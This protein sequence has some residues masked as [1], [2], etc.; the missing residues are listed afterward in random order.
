MPS[1]V[2]DL[3][4]FGVPQGFVDESISNR[5]VWTVRRRVTT[6]GAGKDNQEIVDMATKRRVTTPGKTG[7]D[8]PVS[9]QTKRRLNT[10]GSQGADQSVLGLGASKRRIASPHYEVRDVRNLKSVKEYRAPDIPEAKRMVTEVSETQRL[11]NLAGTVSGE[12]MMSRRR[13]TMTRGGTVQGTYK[14]TTQVDRPPTYAHNPVEDGLSLNRVGNDGNFNLMGGKQRV[15]GPG[16][17]QQMHIADM[18]SK[19]SLDDPHRH[20]LRTTHPLYG[21]QRQSDEDTGLGA[22]KIRT[23]EPD[24][25]FRLYAR[26]MGGKT[27]HP[28]ASC[29]SE[30]TGDHMLPKMY[31][32]THSRSTFIHP[33]YINQ[34]SYASSYP[35]PPLPAGSPIAS[36]TTR[37]W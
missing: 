15:P 35:K 7:G 30:S 22:V 23:A 37:V 13:P 33:K 26:G 4:G 29:L 14:Q 36:T 32:E 3:P 27:R 19:V 16:G 5:N 34:V 17:A 12:M 1:T 10:P 21:R 2:L 20:V 9:F 31:P 28:V 25:G 6:P 11:R 24:S 8:C 18:D